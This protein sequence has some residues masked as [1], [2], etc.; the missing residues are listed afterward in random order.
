MCLKIIIIVGL[1]SLLEILAIRHCIKLLNNT[2][3][4]HLYCNNKFDNL[5]RAKYLFDFVSVL[6]PGN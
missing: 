3:K 5:R 4:I 6:E 2:I 1:T